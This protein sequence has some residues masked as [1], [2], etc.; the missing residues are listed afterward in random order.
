MRHT[1]DSGVNLAHNI[2]TPFAAVHVYSYIVH[3]FHAERYNLNYTL[4]IHEASKYL[5]HE[6]TGKISRFSNKMSS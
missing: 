4:S 3:I 2:R 1:N 6:N 5:N